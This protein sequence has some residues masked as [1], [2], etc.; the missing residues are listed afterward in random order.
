MLWLGLE[1]IANR[2]TKRIGKLVNIVETDVALA[3]LDPANIGAIQPRGMS[4]FLLR[5][6]VC[7]PQKAQAF[8]KGFAVRGDGHIS[9]LGV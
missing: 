5:P 3:A 2:H 1:Q 6:T 8:A 7:C 4:E 9:I